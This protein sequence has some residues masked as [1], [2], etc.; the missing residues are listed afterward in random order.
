MKRCV[1]WGAVLTYLALISPNFP[2]IC[3]SVF[4]PARFVG[5]TCALPTLSLT[6]RRCG[7]SQQ[8]ARPTA[9][10]WGT[11]ALYLD[12]LAVAPRQALHQ[13]QKRVRPLQFRRRLM[14]LRSLHQ[15]LALPRSLHQLLALLRS[16]RPLLALPRTHRP[17]LGLP[18]T[19]RP[20][21]G[22]PRTRRQSHLQNRRLTCLLPLGRPWTRRRS[23]RQTP[24]LR[25]ALPQSLRPISPIRLAKL[26]PIRLAKLRPIRLEAAHSRRGQRDH[27]PCQKI[28]PPLRLLALPPTHRQPQLS[29]LPPTLRLGLVLVRR[30]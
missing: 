3:P 22:L 19:R 16:L 9:A 13:H 4:C 29:A 24:P 11:M 20:L 27:S 23:L 30:T 8:G 18:R 5:S 14:P 7:G 10:P 28:P 12:S 1:F 15:L 2:G 6:S 26:R 25:S 21:L 17:L